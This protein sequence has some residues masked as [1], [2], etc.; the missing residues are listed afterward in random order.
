MRCVEE[1]ISEQEANVRSRDLE[2]S[3]M[4]EPLATLQ[5]NRVL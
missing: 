4:T 1:V 2:L 5:R 3:N